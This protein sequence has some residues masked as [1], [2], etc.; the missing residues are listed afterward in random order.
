MELGKIKAAVAKMARDKDIDVQSAWDVFFFDEFLLRLSKSKYR[1]K[2]VFKGGFYLQSFLGAET[3]STMDIDFKMESGEHSNEQLKSILAEI[4]SLDDDAVSFSVVSVD[5]IVAESKYGGKTIKIDAT[6]YNIR[7]R[8]GVDIG[9]GDIVTPY[10]IDYS[11]RMSFKD[12]ECKLLAYPIETVIAEKFETLISK[13]TQN[14]RLK[15]LFDLYLLNGEEYDVD[16]LNAAI[17]NTFSLRQTK[18][19]KEYISN[20]LDDVFSFDRIK[21][22]YDNFARKNKYVKDVTF[23]MCESAIYSIFAKLK[24][25]RKI[26]L[27]DYNIELHVVR[28]GEDETDKV[29]GWSNSHLTS[30]GEMQVRLLLP[31]IEEYDRFISSDLERAKETSEIINSKLNM[32]VVFNQNFRETNNGDLANLSKEEFVGTYKKYLFS[33]MKMDE[34]YPNGESPADFYERVKNEFVKML[35]SNKDKKILLVTH[36][37]VITV[38]RCLLNG[39][40]YSNKLKIAPETGSIIKLK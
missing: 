25:E 7:K 19:D 15:D 6:F 22:L 16:D 33:S 39:Y 24:F 1:Q 36:G 18:Y 40:S 17:I 3:R 21:S 12:E 31:Q 27:S 11:Y 37:G 28:H 32:K 2:F 4:C 30:K 23:E 38:I 8:F 26:L 29:G 35:D 14:S 34:K 13:G 20:T 5:D 10:P 9:F